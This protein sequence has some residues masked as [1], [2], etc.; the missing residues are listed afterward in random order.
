VAE[1]FLDK[2]LGAGETASFD[3]YDAGRV[4]ADVDSYSSAAPSC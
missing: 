4:V 1:A 3:A 2:V